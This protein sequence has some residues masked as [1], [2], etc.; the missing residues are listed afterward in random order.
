M[1]SNRGGSRSGAGRPSK[2]PA[3]RKQ[4]ISVTLDADAV[5]WLELQG[6]RSTILNRL[7]REL[8]LHEHSDDD[9]QITKIPA[10]A[11]A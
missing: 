6:D 11:D 2:T 4:K 1:L 3:E 5:S 8:M 7:V 9:G 10:C